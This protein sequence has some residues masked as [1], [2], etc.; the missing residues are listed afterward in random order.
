MESYSDT[1]VS[2]NKIFLSICCLSPLVF[3]PYILIVDGSNIGEIIFC[4]F[5]ISIPCFAIMGI[6]HFLLK[7]FYEEYIIIDKDEIIYK[8]PEIDGQKEKIIQISEL[9]SIL[10]ENESFAFVP[11]SRNSIYL[12]DKDSNKHVIV[13]NKIAAFL[14]ISKVTLEKLSTTFKIPIH[15]KFYVMS[16]DLRQ[17]HQA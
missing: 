15:I 1:I 4:V 10:W 13:K 9:K 3:M 16:G 6:S 7:R 8:G 5:I 17:R 14:S 11:G 12:V 2:Y